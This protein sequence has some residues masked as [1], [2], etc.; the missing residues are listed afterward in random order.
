[1]TSK[2]AR[3][4]KEQNGRCF[5]CSGETYLVER[6]E[7]KASVKARF[8][9][10]EGKGSGTLLRRRRATLEPSTARRPRNKKGNPMKLS[11]I[12]AALLLSGSVNAQQPDTWGQSLR[13]THL[14][15]S[16]S[17][18]EHDFELLK[19]RVEQLEKQLAQNAMGSHPDTRPDRDHS[20]TLSYEEHQRKLALC[21]VE[22]STITDPELRKWC[23]AQSRRLP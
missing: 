1:M 10:P 9:I 16:A 15:R 22:L 5:Y 18:A 3:L 19:M 4:W 12:I 23:E 21:M 20:G 14:G 13:E 7:A 11:L 17:P 8:G 6:G 2:I